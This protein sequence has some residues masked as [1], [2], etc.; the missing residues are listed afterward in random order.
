ME[1][2]DINI[3]PEAAKRF[4]ERTQEILL[5]VQALQHVRDPNAQTPEYGE[6]QLVV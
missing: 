1:Q 3:H 2:T 4:D 6:R 5:G